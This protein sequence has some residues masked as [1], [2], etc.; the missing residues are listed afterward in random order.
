MLRFT[1][2]FQNVILQLTEGN[3][4][5]AQVLWR[6][7]VFNM[8]LVGMNYT[9]N[10]NGQRYTTLQVIDD[11]NSYFN[12]P[13]AGRGCVGKKVDSVYVGSYDCS[14]LKVGMEID[15]LYDKAIKTAKGTFQPIKRVDIIG[16]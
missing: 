11:Y 16:K 7:D 1:S 9:T 4:K 13:S 8:T 6:K 10:E 14:A 5:F 3:I 15:I 2:F 12:N